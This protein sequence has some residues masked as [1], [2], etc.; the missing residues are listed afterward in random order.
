MEPEQPSPD[1]EQESLHEETHLPAPTLWPIGFAI[2][3]VVAPRR[4]DHRPAADLDDRRGDRDRL[5][6]PL[7]A[8]RDRRAAWRA[9]RRRARARASERHAAPQA[10]EHDVTV[11]EVPETGGHPQRLPRGRDARPRRGDRRPDHACRSPASR[12][13]RRSSASSCTRSTSGRSR[14]S[15]ST[16]GTSRRSSSIPP[17]ERSRGAR[18]SSA[19][20]VSSP[21]RT[22]RSN[23]CRASRSS[24]TTAPTSAAR[25]RRTARPAR[26]TSASRSSTSTRRTGRSTIDPVIPAGYGC[27]CHGGQYDPEGNRIAGPPVRALDRYAFEIVTAASSSSAPYSVSQV[28]GTG[29][30]PRSTSTR[31]AGPGEHVDGPGAVLLSPP[32]A[33]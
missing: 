6:H 26:S 24:R 9:G 3:I 19:T 10:D 14:T 7:G 32:A 27:P 29:A 1:T 28:E 2:G 31:Q 15:R 33:A 22:S 25:C 23:R 21:T 30:R 12:F 20:T 11:V 17:R 8:R 4:A 16:S 18:P 5:R 13:C